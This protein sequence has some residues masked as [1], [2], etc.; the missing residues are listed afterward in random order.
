MY[1]DESY[2]RRALQ[3]GPPATRSSVPPTP[4]CSRPSWAVARDEFYLHPALTRVLVSEVL[5][6]THLP[7]HRFVMSFRISASERSKFCGW[8]HW[9]IQTRRLLTPSLSL[10]KDVSKAT[11]AA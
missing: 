8:W 11:G 10:R 1:D 3:A 9:A 4:T 5:S 2:L 6:E 7:T